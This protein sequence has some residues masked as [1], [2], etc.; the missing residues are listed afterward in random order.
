MKTT[1]WLNE[2]RTADGNCS[3]YWLE[4]HEYCSTENTCSNYSGVDLENN[5]NNSLVRRENYS[6]TTS[7]D[8]NNASNDFGS[9]RSWAREQ[10]S[11]SGNSNTNCNHWFASSGSSSDMKMSLTGDL[12]QLEQRLTEQLVQT[13]MGHLSSTNKQISWMSRTRHIEMTN[14]DN[15]RDIVGDHRNRRMDYSTTRFHC[16]TEVHFRAQRS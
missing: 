11:T 6:W 13:T 15:C 7:D 14:L 3:C 4:C 8:D 2:L 5:N 10:S 12:L 9:C 1:Y 16:C